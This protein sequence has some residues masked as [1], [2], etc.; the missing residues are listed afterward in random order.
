MREDLPLS[1][2]RGGVHLRVRLAPKASR[3]AVLGVDRT[4]RGPA[5]KVAVTAVPE[6]GKA[7]AALIRLLAKEMKRPKSAFALVRGETDRTKVIR[8]A[9]DPARIMN[10]VSQWLEGI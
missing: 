2:V 9:G 10:D 4:G 8:I 6:K 5:L 7:N 1:E 3:T